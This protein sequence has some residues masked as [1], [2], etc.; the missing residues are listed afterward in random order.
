MNKIHISSEAPGNLDEK[1]F[2]VALGSANETL[3]ILRSE[4]FTSITIDLP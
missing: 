2:F 4:F 1:T 3:Q